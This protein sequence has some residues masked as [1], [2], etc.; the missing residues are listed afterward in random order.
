MIYSIGAILFGISCILGIIGSYISLKLAQ[1]YS[2]LDHPESDYS[3]KKQ[4]K[5]IPLMG[6]TGFVMSCSIMTGLI[7]GIAKYDV[8]GSQ[9]FLYHGLYQP[10]SY[11]WVL[12][13]VG[14]LLIAGYLDDTSR[15]SILGRVV[16]TALALCVSVVFA[17]IKIE[18]L[19]YPFNQLI[20][21]L[22]LIPYILGFVWLGICLFTTKVLDGH[23]GL[24][25]SVGGSG[26]LTIACVAMLSNVNQPLLYFFGL[27]WAGGVFGF[28]PFN[29]PNAKS[30]LGDGGSMI[31][32][33]MI[34]VL[35]II[36]GAKI[37]T[38][39]S[40][41]GWFVIDLFFVWTRRVIDGRNPLTSSD[42]YHWHQRL[43]DSG[44][45]K[46]QVLIISIIVVLTTSRLGLVLTSYN[47]LIIILAQVVILLAVFVT[48]YSI[49]L[50]KNKE[51]T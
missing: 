48:T 23:D 8:F 39:G 27:I 9:A 37:A 2:I 51:N 22:P 28:L 10:I 33:Y 4:T 3:R 7:A 5:P 36:S 32:G 11:F 18:S 50:F 6:A 41:I 24:V 43:V 49:A 45:N 15:I 44:L 35:A 47:K 19:S 25:A 20:P 1:K 17:D 46:I 42:R 14:I 34:G 29:F 26:F 12:V 21:S 16:L 31:I 30:Y 38:V 13:S 40:A